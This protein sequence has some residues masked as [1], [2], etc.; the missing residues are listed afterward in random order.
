MD[1]HREVLKKFKVVQLRKL[2]RQYN[3]HNSIKG[4][5]KMRKTDLIDNILKYKKRIFKSGK[6]KSKLEMSKEEYK[7]KKAKKENKV[8]KQLKKEE[9][10]NR[11]L[12]GISISIRK[13]AVKW[14]KQ[15]SNKKY[16]G[17]ALSKYKQ[18]SQRVRNYIEKEHP[19][20][21]KLLAFMEEKRLENLEKKNNK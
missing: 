3:L 12:E 13:L 2:I 4:Y 6:V 7:V 11:V 18:V 21:H 10:L 20:L 17:E 9:K 8:E 16:L 5:S 19:K 14:N 15:R 1:K